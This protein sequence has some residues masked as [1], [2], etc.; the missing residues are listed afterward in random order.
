M[1][2]K[3][4]YIKQAKIKT[5]NML[6]LIKKHKYNAILSLEETEKEV[7]NQLHELKEKKATIEESLKNLINST[8]ETWES[9][10]EEFENSTKK[11]F[12]DSLKNRMDNMGSLI[13]EWSSRTDETKNA[14]LEKA[15]NEIRDLNTG[16]SL[17]EEKASKN[18]E[19][20][21][22]KIKEQID[23]LKHKK[24]EM[25]EKFEE[26]KNSNDNVFEDIKKGFEET[27]G[28]FKRRFHN[29]K[30]NIK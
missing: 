2:I 1:E 3:D 9:A 15:K 4:E 28:F 18:K 29:L 10:K 27:K 25:Q 26:A 6:S 17:L 23:Y 13:K 21:R 11:S 16:I 30:N 12:F 8:D 22:N 19:F 5:T 20:T 7:T 24:D 14:F